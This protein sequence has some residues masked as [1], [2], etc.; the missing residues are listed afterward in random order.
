VDLRQEVLSGSRAEARLALASADS[1]PFVDDRFDVV[2][3]LTMMSSV[4]DPGMRGCIAAEMLRVLRPGGLVLWYD[5]TVNPFN[6]DV[7]G[8]RPAELRELFR[9]TVMRWQRVTL[10]PPLARLLA[11]HSWMICEA[12][13]RLPWLRTHVLATCRKGPGAAPLPTTPSC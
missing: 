8:I 10:A 2:C 5:F 13:E 6:P 12:L 9:G 7:A 4:L 11:P 1:L 3:Q